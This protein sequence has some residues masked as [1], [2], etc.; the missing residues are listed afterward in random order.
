MLNSESLQHFLMFLLLKQHICIVRAFQ[1]KKKKNPQNLDILGLFFLLLTD[2]LI[3]SHNSR[4]LFCVSA[5]P[6]F[7][8]LMFHL[9]NDLYFT[10]ADYFLS[11]A[12]LPMSPTRVLFKSAI[13]NFSFEDSSRN[14]YFLQFISS[15][16]THVFILYECC[17]PIYWTLW[18]VNYIYV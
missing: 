11:C 7:F 15:K 16:I 5:L 13:T 12:S 10:L 8:L 2:D 17:L 14:G 1:G 4:I 18:H 9:D 6:F 3:L